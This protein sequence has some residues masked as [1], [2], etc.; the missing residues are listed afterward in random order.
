MRNDV[1]SAHCEST[2]EH[3]ETKYKSLALVPSRVRPIPP[4]E[5]VCGV[6][7]L[8]D[9]WHHCAYDNRYQTSSENE[10]TSKRLNRRERPI[11]E[12]YD[13]ARDPRKYD[14]DHEDMPL[15]ERKGRVE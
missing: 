9:V 14:I 6:W 10:E 5:T 13:S 15:L 4:H 3:A 8:L 7:S 11:C 2:V 1:R 12:Q